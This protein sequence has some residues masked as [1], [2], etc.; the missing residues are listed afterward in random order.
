[1]ERYEMRVSELGS[2][3]ATQR[4]TNFEIFLLL[5]RA[6]IRAPSNFWDL[7]KKIY[8]HTHISIYFFSN[9]SRFDFSF[10]KLC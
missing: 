9:C 5:D 1:M 8:I 10:G 7:F 3:A 2:A 6:T 4:L